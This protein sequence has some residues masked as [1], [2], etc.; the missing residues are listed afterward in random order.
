MNNSY[1][2]TDDPKHLQRLFGHQF[3]EPW[4]HWVGICCYYIINEDYCT[5]SEAQQ[6]TGCAGAQFL[7]EVRP[8]QYKQ[9]CGREHACAT[10]FCAP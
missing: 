10:V 7:D 5:N 2:G 6:K 4:K 3:S 1:S 9:Y 8:K